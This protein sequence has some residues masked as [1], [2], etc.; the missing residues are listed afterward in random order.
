MEEDRKEVEVVIFDRDPGRRQEVASALCQAQPSWIV[1]PLH[2]DHA[3]TAHRHIDPASVVLISAATCSDREALGLIHRL[4]RVQPAARIIVV[5]FPEKAEQPFRFVEAGAW[6]F[7]YRRESPSDVAR[8]V[9][10]AA[11]PAW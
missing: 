6:G 3:V 1:R 9:S 5:D 4:H 7:A 10:A 2:P 11:R 8:K